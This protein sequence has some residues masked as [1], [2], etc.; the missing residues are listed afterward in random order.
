MTGLRGVAVLAPGRGE[1]VNRGQRVAKL[2]TW[3]ISRL[4][5]PNDDG[6]QAVAG[7]PGGS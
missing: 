3:K 5:H 6:D 7:Q 2:G 4:V 1:P